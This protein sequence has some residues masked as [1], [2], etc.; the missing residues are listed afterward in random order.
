MDQFERRQLQ[1]ASQ[2]MMA[3][4]R[5]SVS[6]SQSHARMNHNR[7]TNLGQASTERTAR[8]FIPLADLLKRNHNDRVQY[9][10]SMLE[11]EDA[12]AGGPSQDE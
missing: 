4:G 8:S 12:T 2:L 11:N 9:H 6:Q 7:S 5:N 10:L 1:E 3:T